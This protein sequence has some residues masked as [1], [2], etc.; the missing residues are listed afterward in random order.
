MDSIARR[1]SRY[2]KS[3]AGRVM[4]NKAAFEKWYAEF[5]SFREMLAGDKEIMFSAWQASRATIEIER[6][7]EHEWMGEYPS[8]DSFLDGYA[9]GWNDCVDT[10]TSHGIRIKGKTECDS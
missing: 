8:H 3:S 2:S 7:P 9:N 5:T 6:E 10:I 4:D 1:Y